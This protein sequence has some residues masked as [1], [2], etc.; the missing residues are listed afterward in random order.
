MRAPPPSRST[1]AAVTTGGAFCARVT[2]V[3]H[4]SY[5]SPVSRRGLSNMGSAFKRLARPLAHAAVTIARRAGAVLREARPAA[6]PRADAQNEDYDMPV[7]SPVST[8]RSCTVCTSCATRRATVWVTIRRLSLPKPWQSSVPSGPG[9]RTIL[10]HHFACKG[11]QAPARRQLTLPSAVR[12]RCRWRPT[13]PPPSPRGVKLCRTARLEGNCC[14]PCATTI[15]LLAE[16][17]HSEVLVGESS[18]FV[19]NSSP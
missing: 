19:S 3:T 6:Q 13:I 12:S 17:I 4:R 5:L 15:R 11:F 16:G 8:T 1:W 7:A 14:P 9:P 18:Q 2:A 10:M